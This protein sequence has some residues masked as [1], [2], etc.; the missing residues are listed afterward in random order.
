MHDVPQPS[1]PRLMRMYPCS[2]NLVPH[3]FFSSLRV[4]GGVA[5]DHELASTTRP[6]S[7]VCKRVSSSLTS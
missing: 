1:L 2:P 7:S 4:G 6:H 5:R 3:V